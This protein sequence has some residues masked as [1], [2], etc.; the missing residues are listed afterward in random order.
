MHWKRPWMWDIESCWRDFGN[1]LPRDVWYYGVF[2]TATY[3]ETC[4]MHFVS[5]RRKYSNMMLV[6]HIC[7]MGIVAVV[8]HY[9]LYA[10]GTLNMFLHDFSDIFIELAKCTKYLKF[11]V[12]TKVLFVM[13]VVAWLVCRMY[14]YP[15]WF[16]R[17]CIEDRYGVL[18]K[19]NLYYYWN[20]V[21]LVLLGLHTIWT[22]MILRSVVRAI[23]TG[24]PEDDR[25]DDD[26]DTK[27]E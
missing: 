26:D 4:A 8:W 16:L 5:V 6:H 18:R 10:I 9:G 22:Y 12:P 27:D 3:L 20:G 21:S 17:S 13:F 19:I 15:T 23:R 11:E 14:L 1:G 7:L 2:L 25:S 24:V